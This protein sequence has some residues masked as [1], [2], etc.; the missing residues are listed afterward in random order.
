MMPLAEGFTLT[1]DQ[2][3]TE[4]ISIKYMQLSETAVYTVCIIITFICTTFI[5]IALTYCIKYIIYWH[6]YMLTDTTIHTDLLFELT[7]PTK[8]ITPHFNNTHSSLANIT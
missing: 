3:Q 6:K 2:T 1:H 8:T 7:K 4:T 5:I